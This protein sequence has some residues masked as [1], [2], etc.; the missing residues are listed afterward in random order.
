MSR[1]E[2]PPYFW[3]E[4]QKVHACLFERLML[5][6]IFAGSPKDHVFRSF[7]VLDVWLDKAIDEGWLDELED[8]ELKQ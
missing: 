3:R 4:L 1:Q 6:C 5:E 8:V 2:P 7:Q